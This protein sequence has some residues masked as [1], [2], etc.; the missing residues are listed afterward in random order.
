[1]ST[2]IVIQRAGPYLRVIL[3]ASEPDWNGVWRTV[4]L[5]LQDRI[6]LAEIIAPSYKDEEPE[7]GPVVGRPASKNAGW[8]RS[9]TGRASVQPRHGHLVA[10]G[11]PALGDTP[12]VGLRHAARGAHRRGR[13]PGLNAAIR[14]VVRRGVRW[15]GMEFVGFQD[16]WR[17]VL[18]DGTQPLG[19]PETTGILPRGG[20]ILGSSGPD[21][22]RV[23]DGRDLVIADARTARARRAHRDRGRGNAGRAAQLVEDGVR[24]VGVP[25]TIDNDVP[26]PTSRSGSRRPR[27]SR[28][29][30]STGSTRRPR[31][32]TG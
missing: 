28:R 5:E 1:M 30:P 12:A 18:D 15:H 32:T 3:P 16:G 22:Y 31:A 27:R 26:A 23:E 20:T 7:R 11:R 14:A 2:D 6:R 13:L 10:N 24:I 9:S 25:K 4:E 19:V 21:P 29:M 8:T 17:G